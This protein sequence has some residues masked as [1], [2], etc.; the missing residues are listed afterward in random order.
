[1]QGL[2]LVGEPRPVVL[3]D[4]TDRLPADYVT[5]MQTWGAG[6]F[7]GR[8]ELPDPSERDGRFEL[9]QAQFK[10]RAPSEIVA[11]RWGQLTD[12]DV[13]HGIVLGVDTRGAALVGLGPERLVWLAVTGEVIELRGLEGVVRRVRDHWEG[14]PLAPQTHVTE[15]SQRPELYAAL[16]AGDEAAADR[17]VARILETEHPVDAQLA[18]AHHLATTSG[19]ANELRAAYAEQ[20]LRV[21]KRKSDR[22][23]AL[24]IR[25]IRDALKRGSVPPEL[26]APLTELAVA[27]GIFAGSGDRTE[28][29]LL[30]ELAAHPD[31][32][33]TR[34]VLADHLE[35]R[36]ELERAEA[37]RHAQALGSPLPDAAERGFVAPRG[38]KPVD[39]AATLAGYIE[40]WRTD[41]PGTDIAPLVAALDALHPQE[42]QGYVMLLVTAAGG[43][44]TSEPFLV[45]AIDHTWPLLVLS[46]RSSERPA[47]LRLLVTTKTKAA[48]PFLLAIVRNPSP[49]TYRA[50]SYERDDIAI[51]FGD[52]GGKLAK[53]EVDELVQ[54]LAP[55]APKAR[56]ELAA[57][58]LVGWGRDDRVFEGYLRHFCDA[59]PFS[60]T[61]LSKRRKEPRVV[62]VLSA[63]FAREEA[64][65]LRG[66][67]LCY[68]KDYGLLSA[69]LKKLG[70][71]GAKEA[72]ERYRKNARMNDNAM[73]PRE[74]YE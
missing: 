27:K 66:N 17:A 15:P 61:A 68:S 63:A 67:V 26:L 32:A 39:G 65:A 16:E 10:A 48:A 29:A 72:H 6:M 13:A 46:L 70:V 51:A 8:F 23:E 55:D 20:C 44:Y 31:D 19:I 22:V 38:T 56:V 28:L 9:F 14:D 12:D 25:G 58:L 49:A 62:E 2:A 18:I 3:D 5:L 34:L 50:W 4:I 30:E 41:D 64:G 74:R 42:R 69:Y 57:R 45:K 73:N 33:A 52:V 35:S 60:V 53:A 71:A 21:A 54:W 7:L 43:H 11:G 40:R 37:L 47:A 1:M 24:D 59:H 36:G